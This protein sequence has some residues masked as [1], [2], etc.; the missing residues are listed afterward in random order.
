MIRKP[1][2]LTEAEAAGLW[3]AVQWMALCLRQPAAAGEDPAAMAKERQRLAAARRALA[4]LQRARRE[5]R[6]AKA[7]VASVGGSKQ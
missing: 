3:H 6:A 2:D 7:E 1:I 5:A 4:K